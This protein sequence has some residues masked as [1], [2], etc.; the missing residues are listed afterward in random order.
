M[1]HTYFSLGGGGQGLREVFWKF[2]SDLSHR[3]WPILKNV[4]RVGILNLR[5][6]SI[7]VNEGLGF[8]AM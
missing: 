4:G 3:A 8:V 2:Y 5:E 7:V 6:R 1:T